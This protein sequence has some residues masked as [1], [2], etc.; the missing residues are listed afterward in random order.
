MYF[1][2]DN[3]GRM[4]PTNRSVFAFLSAC[5]I[6]ASILAYIVSFHDALVDIAFPWLGILLL[7]WMALIF[8]IYS[9]DYP[10]SRAP[11]FVWKGFTRDMPKWV[12]PCSWLLSLI[13]L[14]HFVWFAVHAGWGVPEIQDGQ[15]ILGARGHI[16]KVLTQTEYFTLKEAELRMLPALMIYFYFLPVTYWWFRRNQQKAA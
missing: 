9:R 3:A 5:G 6:V 7:G 13:C 14:A 8:P 4:M 2:R 1:V 16:L 11:S 15:Y 10:A 12:A